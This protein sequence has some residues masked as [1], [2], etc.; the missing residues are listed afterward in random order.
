MGLVSRI[1]TLREAGR[2]PFGTLPWY[3]RT[4]DGLRLSPGALGG[5]GQRGAPVAP[6]A[7]RMIQQAVQA[8]AA[9][10]ADETGWWAGGRNGYA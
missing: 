10:P 3:L 5:A 8:S 9:V 4:V 1:A 7:V 2:L 6:P